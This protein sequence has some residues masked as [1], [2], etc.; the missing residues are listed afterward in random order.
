M[1]KKNFSLDLIIEI[2]GLS[3]EEIPT[4]H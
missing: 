4:L 1:L 2:T 3:Q